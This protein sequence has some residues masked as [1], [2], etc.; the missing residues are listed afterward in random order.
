MGELLMEAE[1]IKATAWPPF[2]LSMLSPEFKAVSSTVARFD[3]LIFLT[4][5]KEL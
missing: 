5:V 4:S 2:D 3:P 1:I